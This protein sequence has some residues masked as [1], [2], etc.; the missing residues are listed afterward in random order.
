MKRGTKTLVL[1]LIVL[2]SLSSIAYTRSPEDTKEGCPCNEI[3]GGCIPSEPQMEEVEKMI[4]KP[5]GE[6]WTRV[7]YEWGSYAYTRTSYKWKWRSYMYWDI[8]TGPSIG[9][10]HCKIRVTEKYYHRY[11]IYYDTCWHKVIKKEYA[12]TKVRYTQEALVCCDYPCPVWPKCW[13]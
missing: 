9:W 12:G 3:K 11:K 5:T 10:C 6:C 4:V 8:I 13:Y 2:I 1:T 7:Y